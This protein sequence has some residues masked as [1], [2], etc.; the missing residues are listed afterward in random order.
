M[1]QFNIRPQR[2]TLINDRQIN[3]RYQKNKI[4][5]KESDEKIRSVKFMK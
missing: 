4:D 2:N 3:E 1:Q 5:D